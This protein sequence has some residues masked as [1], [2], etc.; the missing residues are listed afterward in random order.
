MG[1]MKKY[2]VKYGVQVKV[3]KSVEVEVYAEN[4]EEAIQKALDGLYDEY[5]DSEYEYDSEDVIK[6]DFNK[7]IGD[8][9]KEIKWNM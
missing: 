1:A 3:W 2:F 5:I 7:E 4:E 6:V 9:I 8:Y